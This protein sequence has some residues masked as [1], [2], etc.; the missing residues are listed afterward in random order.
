MKKQIWL[1]LLLLVFAASCG[2]DEEPRIDPPSSNLAYE[3]VFR[4]IAPLLKDTTGFKPETMG[5]VDNALA[6]VKGG[7]LWVG[8]FT[9]NEFTGLEKEWLSSFNVPGDTERI[10]FFNFTDVFKLDSNSGFSCFIALHNSD[11]LDEASLVA[12]YWLHLLDDGTMEIIYQFE[13]GSI[14]DLR[15]GV[16]GDNWILGFY[17]TPLDDYRQ[18]LCYQGDVLASRV[19]VTNEDDTYFFTGVKDEKLLIN[20]YTKESGET[21]QWLGDTPVEET[22]RVHQGYGEYVTY[23]VDSVRLSNIVRTEWGYVAQ[24][25]YLVKRMEGNGTDVIV[26]DFLLLN[27]EGK[28]VYRELEGSLPFYRE[29]YDGSVLLY[30]EGSCIIFS[31]KGD[32]IVHYESPSFEWIKNASQQMEAITY[33]DVVVLLLYSGYE[34]CRYDL[35]NENGAVW[36]TPVDVLNQYMT[37]DARLTVSIESKSGNIWQ[38]KC[39]ILYYDGSTKQVSFAVNIDTGEIVS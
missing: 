13:D 35:R 39:D 30:S 19:T 15:Y 11:A 10:L 6:F 14:Y 24:P 17:K 26:K 21:H 27:G 8:L 37:P 28:I 1:W 31:P 16:Y 12:A 38:Y 36:E 4:K 3:V 34:L 5:G 20:V 2:D 9:D 32:E 33:E 23:A 7:K 25:E 18:F 22:I 29:W